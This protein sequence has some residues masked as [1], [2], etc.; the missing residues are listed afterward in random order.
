MDKREILQR[1][2]SIRRKLGKTTDLLVTDKY[3]AAYVIGEAEGML[4][5]LIIG[6][7][8]DLKYEEKRKE[9]E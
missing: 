7:E 5:C 8:V 3:Q 4:D 1:V 2:R 6:L 9:V